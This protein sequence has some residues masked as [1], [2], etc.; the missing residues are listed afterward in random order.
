MDDRSQTVNQYPWFKLYII[1][2]RKFQFKKGRLFDFAQDT[3]PIILIPM[4]ELSFYWIAQLPQ[5]FNFYIDNIAIF[6]L[7]HPSGRAGE[8]QVAGFQRHDGGYVSD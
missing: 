1:L 7:A 8:E 2:P 6:E 4:L 5:P 3:C